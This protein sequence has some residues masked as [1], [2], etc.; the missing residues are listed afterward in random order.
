[1]CPDLDQ[2]KITPSQIPT[3]T[4]KQHPISSDTLFKDNHVVL[5]QHHDEY[6]CLRRTRQN[7]LILTK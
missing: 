5:I 3:T 4:N 2:N 1:M 7:K 6:Y